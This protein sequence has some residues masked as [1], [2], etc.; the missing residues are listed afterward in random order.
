ML[1][2]LFQGIKR[3]ISWST[4]SMK[5]ALHSSQ[6]WISTRTKKENFWPI[7][8]MTIDVKNPQKKLANQIQ[9]QQNDH[10]P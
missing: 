9:Q 5:L 7:S 10:T 3:E 8:L 4:D 2:K 6:N 1:L